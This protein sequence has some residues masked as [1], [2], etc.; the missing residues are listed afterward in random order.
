MGESRTMKGVFLREATGLVREYG[1]FDCFWI[2]SL[3]FGS[4]IL[5]GL[6]FYCSYYPVSGLDGIPWL[7]ILMTLALSFFVYWP[8]L[9]M[10]VAMPRSGGDY[11]FVSRTIHP[12]I[13]FMNNFAFTIAAL[14]GIGISV[15]WILS[16]GLTAPLYLVG[17]QTGNTALSGIAAFVSQPVPAFGLGTLIL[18]IILVVNTFGSSA[19]KVF[20]RF[21]FAVFVVGFAL[22]IWFLASYRTSDFL[23]AFNAL[24]PQTGVTVDKIFEIAK[25]TGWHAPNYSVEGTLPQ[26]PIAMFSFYGAS[27][28]AYFAGEVKNIR[29]TQPVAT[30]VFMFSSAIGWIVLMLL[31]Y[32]FFGDQF[33]TA[34]SWVSFGP[35]SAQNPWPLLMSPNALV[36]ILNVPAQLLFNILMIVNW[37]QWFLF[38]WMASTRNMFAWAFDRIFP[39]RFARV[40]ERFKSPVLAAVTVFIAAEIFQYLFV[41]TP[42]FTGQFNFLLFLTSALIIPNIA[43]AVFPYRKREMFNAAPSIVKMK[44]G[45][46]PLI[47]ILGTLGAL[48]MVWLTYTMLLLPFLGPAN[49]AAFAFFFGIYAAGLIVFFISWAVRR[50]Q[51]LDMTKIFQ[52][53]PPE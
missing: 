34:V 11:V 22:V 42:L 38:F 9:Q 47:T 33:F 40:N 50:G 7:A 36:F 19:I 27:F 10:S 18:L 15:P 53:I 51:G 31:T 41:F 35:G 52:E 29:R 37:V 14:I 17:I 3:G 48:V 6:A 13:G 30:L 21:Q 32:N 8:I 12:A 45:S 44:V 25:A 5:T 39:E 26:M 23:A 20:N 1:W 4:S 46:I 16:L 24:A 43:A 49:L 2:V 28:S